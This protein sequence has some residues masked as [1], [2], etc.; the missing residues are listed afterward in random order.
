MTHGLWHGIYDMA[1]RPCVLIKPRPKKCIPDR[2]VWAFSHKG[3]S[4]IWG[5]S[6]F[7]WAHL[8]LY[9]LDLRP[10]WLDA[11]TKRTGKT[12]SGRSWI[13]TQVRTTWGL[14]HRGDDTG[15]MVHGLCH[16][17]YDTGFMVHGLWYTSDAGVR[18]RAT[19]AG[20]RAGRSVLGR[21]QWPAGLGVRAWV[22]FRA[23][24]GI[25][26]WVAMV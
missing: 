19:R 17:A 23:G 21:S 15:I 20:A 22:S 3:L 12:F 25:K 2:F 11:H 13:R 5:R 14:W 18:T 1:V 4:K 26:V 16:R 9:F 7:F 24:F 10:F 6:V 8:A